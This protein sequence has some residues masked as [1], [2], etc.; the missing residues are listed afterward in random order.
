M[1]SANGDGCKCACS[2][3]HISAV[4]IKSTLAQIIDRTI[5]LPATRSKAPSLTS[6]RFGA[7]STIK[8]LPVFGNWSGMRVGKAPHVDAVLHGLLPGLRS[9]HR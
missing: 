3:L 9:H 2:S 6:Q 1:G 7:N 8:N 4:A 5:D